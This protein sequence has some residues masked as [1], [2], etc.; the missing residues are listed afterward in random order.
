VGRLV[1]SFTRRLRRSNSPSPRLDA[2]LLVGH[3]VGRDRAWLHA[4]PESALPAEALPALE[5]WVARRERGEPIAYI[6]GYKDWLSLRVRTD[7]RALIPRPET[8]RLAEAAIEEIAARL[9]SDGAGHAT[10]PIV[11]WEVATGSGA[12]A[13]ALALRFRA[14]LRLRRLRLLASDLSPDALELA[15]ENLEAKGVSSLVSL[16]LADM[17]E[18]AGFRFPRPDVVVA[19]LPYVPSADVGRL[20][21]AASFE[22]RAALDGGDDGLGPIRR[23]LAELPERLAPAGTVLLE[24]G[25]GQAADVAAA[26]RRIGLPM[27]IDTLPDL[28]G[29]ERVVRLRTIGIMSR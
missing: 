8:E 13:L 10:R 2:E 4:H 6:R 9:T 28:A 25:A 1:Q 20:P 22:P 5:E 3:A 27:E 11:A 18:P 19:N 21:V 23:L 15:S 17:L 26:A 16:V 12:V 7:R 14:A 29:V 24:V